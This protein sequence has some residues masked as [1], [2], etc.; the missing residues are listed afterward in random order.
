MATETEWAWVAG[1]F[2]GEG[3]ISFPGKYSVALRVNMTDRD[4]IERLQAVTQ[5]GDV[6]GPITQKGYKDQWFWAVARAA[7]AQMVLERLAP[8]FGVRRSERAAEG[9]KRLALVRRDGFCHRG[10]PM[11]GDN[12]LVG[13]KG[14]YRQCRACMRIRDA[15]RRPRVIKT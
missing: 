2:E 4:I 10:H 15:K 13:R 3:C 6:R 7:E 8:Y 12:L 9:L 11:S 1:I 14:T 5:V